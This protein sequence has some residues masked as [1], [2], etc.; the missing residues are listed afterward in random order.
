MTLHTSFA[1]AAA[2]CCATAWAAD[3]T[4]LN[5]RTGEWETT[6]TFESSG[7]LPIPQE[8]LDKMTPEQRARMEAAMKARAGRGP[9]TTVHKSCVTKETL[10]KPFSGDQIQKSCKETVVTSSPTKQ[11]IHLEC[12]LEGGRQTGS[13]KVE[14][15]DPGNVK[16]SIQMTASNAGR[17]MDANSSFSAKWLGPMC[18]ESK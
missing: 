18:K 17:S 7:Q 9:R 13:I 10:D 15:V 8:M 1:L 3:K 2:F 5:V 11:E 12:E 6:L 4:P 16:G 14:A